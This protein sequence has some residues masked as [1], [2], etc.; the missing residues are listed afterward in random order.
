MYNMVDTIVVTEIRRPSL[1]VEEIEVDGGYKPGTSFWTAVEFNAGGDTASI[2][3]K[4][5]EINIRLLDNPKEVWKFTGCVIMLSRGDYYRYV[6][7]YDK[8]IR[9]AG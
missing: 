2:V 7:T 9:I 3:G 5:N 8:V 4:Y 1:E 6:M